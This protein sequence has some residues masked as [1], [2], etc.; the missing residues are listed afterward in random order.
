MTTVTITQTD[1]DH[2]VHAH[3][4]R[5]P[6][7]LA[8]NR[9]FPQFSFHVTAMDIWVRPAADPDGPVIGGCR[10]PEA[11]AKFIRAFDNWMADQPAPEPISFEIDLWINPLRS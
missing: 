6:G 10:T 4:Q 3:C 8:L 11:L 1:I 2:G 7:A 5:C 9:T